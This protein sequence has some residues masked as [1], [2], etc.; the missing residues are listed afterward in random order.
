MKVHLCDAE[1]IGWA[2]DEELRNIATAAGEQFE[3][4]SLRESEV[5]YSQWWESI[6]GL[7]P[8]DLAGKRLIC[9]LSAEPYRYLGLPRFLEARSRVGLWVAP[10]SRAASQLDTLGW[11]YVRVPYLVDPT[12]FRPL[13]EAKSSLRERY[14]LPRDQYLLGNFHRDSEGSDL[15]RPKLVKGP[16]LL[17]EMAR[18]L[19]A[20]G[21]PVHVVL[22]GPRR[23]WIRDALR[24]ADVPY[25]FVGDQ[26]AGEDFDHNRLER[27]RL[28]EL[29]NAL[30]LALVTSRSE[31]GPHSTLEAA[32][33]ECRILSTPVGIAEDILEPECV[34]S[35]VLDLV[36]VVIGDIRQ[37]RLRATVESQSR[38]IS[39]RHTPT[40]AAPAIR[41]MFRAAKD[42][43]R[44]LPSS[45]SNQEDRR[46]ADRLMGAVGLRRHRVNLWHEFHEPPWGGGNQFLLLLRKGLKER[47]VRILENRLSRRADAYLL[48]A[49]HFDVD[50]FRDRAR[51]ER[52]PIVQ[53]IDGPIQLVRGRDEA[54]DELC[55]QLNR[56]FA[57][58]TILQ[59]RWSIEATYEL[60]FRPQRPVL[61]H[62]AV[63]PDIFHSDGR[64]PYSSDRKIRLIA[65]SWSDNPR[66]GGPFYRDLCERLDL[67]RYEFTFVGRVCEPLPGARMVG[68]VG[69]TDLADLLREH[70]VYITASQADPCSNALIEALACGLPALYLDD[71]GHPELVGFAGLP[72]QT[73]D[74]ALNQ[75]ERLVNHY[76]IFQRLIAVQDAGDVV[77]RY[78]QVLD[79]VARA[80]L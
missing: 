45:S 29:Y 40:A 51:K 68:S 18:E 35:G 21:L 66:K 77:G 17:V 53:R 8:E 78:A 61:I 56:E 25:T 14:G 48:N 23:H 10:S 33:A 41:S 27:T 34:A 62:N 57:D 16:D 28:N 15:S 72:F 37:Q 74:E 3:F 67:D 75:L 39:E 24:R 12:I 65:S 1:G 30:D 36:E 70:D 55:Y 52:L 9:H 6:V 69:S 60:G 63:D 73:V 19:R 46:L 2:L 71:G 20:R 5:V 58:V 31:G 80:E 7:D 59:S 22:A 42:V 47:G 79:L 43:P 54:S 13:Q 32:A 64:I 26:I 44:F 49:V 4:V 50:A 11:P 38:R 76:E